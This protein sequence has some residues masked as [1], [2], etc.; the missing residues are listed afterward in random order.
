M[1]ETQIEIQFKTAVTDL[2]SFIKEK[3]TDF[4]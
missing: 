2:E 4:I 1:L 3:R